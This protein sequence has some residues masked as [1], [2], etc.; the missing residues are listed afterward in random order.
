MPNVHQDGSGYAC[1]WHGSS[2]SKCIEHWKGWQDSWQLKAPPR[3]SAVLRCRCCGSSPEPPIRIILTPSPSPFI[4]IP[5]STSANKQAA[6]LSREI[7]EMR[8]P[9][10]SENQKIKTVFL[11]FSPAHGLTFCTGGLGAPGL[12]EHMTADRPYVFGHNRL[13]CSSLVPPRFGDETGSFTHHAAI[14]AWPEAGRARKAGIRGW[15]TGQTNKAQYGYKNRYS[16]NGC[17]QG[18]PG[19][20]GP[21][22]TA[23]S[24]GPH[25]GALFANCPRGSVKSG[26]CARG[27]QIRGRIPRLRRASGGGNR[28]NPQ[29]LNPAKAGYWAFSFA[30]LAEQAP[31]V[32]K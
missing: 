22:T 4:R 2:F 14:R 7:D 31:H 23:R 18:S 13:R 30:P 24:I 12:H 28:T 32:R 19:L 21:R 29:R 15:G 27:G 1:T 26:A 25:T 9:A 6:R 3:T 5:P 16:T 20:Q 8:H 11:T 10:G 17:G